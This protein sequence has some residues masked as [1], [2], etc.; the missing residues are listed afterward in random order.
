M[1]QIKFY[2]DE[3]VPRAVTEGL[4]R[5]G[6]NVLTVQEAKRSGLSD[7]AQLAFALAEQRVL[8]TMDSDFLILASR[9]VAH[10]GIAYA[11]PT[12]SVGALIR[13]V[14]LLYDVLTAAEMLN[15]VEFL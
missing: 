6:L 3:H 14:M 15:Q 7:T 2:L 12:R 11:S 5:R 1:E 4:R 8:I 10:S 13:S 9:G